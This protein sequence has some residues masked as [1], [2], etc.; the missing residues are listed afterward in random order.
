M[1]VIREEGSGLV[2]VKGFRDLLVC[3][4][5]MA[6]AARVY[7]ATKEF[8]REEQFGLTGQ[9]R[10]AAASVP[11]NIAEGHARRYRRDFR[12]FLS[13]ALGSVAE[14]QT[15]LELAQRLG[16]LPQS[17]DAPLLDEAEELTK[18]LYG[19]LRSLPPVDSRPETRP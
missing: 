1:A 2:D 7:E 6:L 8:P 3:Q 18:M 10:R 9:L 16:Y 19:L 12:S 11:A 15:H 5:A 4:K 13:M 14:M 17:Q